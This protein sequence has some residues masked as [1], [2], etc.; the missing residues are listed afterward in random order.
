MSIDFPKSEFHVTENSFLFPVVKSWEVYLQD[1]GK[2]I[3]TIKAF[4]SDIMMLVNFL[5]ASATI[6]TVSLQDLNSF[7]EWIREGRGIPCSPK[8]F[9]RRVTSIKSFFRWLHVNSRI[10][11]DP[12]ENVVQHSVISPIP[13]ILTSLEQDSIKQAAVKYRTADIPDLRYETLYTLLITTGIKKGECLTLLTNHIVIDIPG[14]PY[15]FIRYSNP[16]NRYKERKILLTKEWV[17]LFMDYKDQFQP[18]DRVFP[19]SP[20]R[21]EYLLEDLGKAAGLTK[22]LSFDMCRW[23]CALNDWKSNLEHDSIRQKLGISKIQWREISMKLHKLAE[24]NPDR[25]TSL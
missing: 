9:A 10:S 2:S 12:A 7:L 3:H 23:T 24:E 20:R 25:L 1:Q 14:E 13:E 22:H 16:G 17:N 19:W 6:S 21:L 11:N 15:L 8:T 5:P 18:L 4:V